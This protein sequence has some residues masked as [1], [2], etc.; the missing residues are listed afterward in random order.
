M[1][2][3]GV[4]SRRKPPALCASPTKTPTTTSL[5]PQLS[6]RQRQLPDRPRLPRATTAKKIA[7]TRL[8]G[9]VP[10]VFLYGEPYPLWPLNNTPRM[11]IVA[12]ALIA[13]S[14]TVNLPSSEASRPSIEANRVLQPASSRAASRAPCSIARGMLVFGSIGGFQSAVGL[15]QRDRMGSP[16]QDLQGTSIPGCV[17]PTS[18]TFTRSQASAAPRRR[19]RSCYG[20]K[21]GPKARLV[22]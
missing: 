12:A 18:Q 16:G 9:A 5:R 15:G 7:A 6:R 4:Q 3:T 19:R 20:A 17:T 11:A 8:P 21:R 13:P 14:M 1:M 2:S 10:T 22:K